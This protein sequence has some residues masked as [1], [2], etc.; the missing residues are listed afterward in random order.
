MISTIRTTQFESLQNLLDI[1]LV[2]KLAFYPGFFLGKHQFL[3]N[4]KVKIE[5]KSNRQDTYL[6][7]NFLRDL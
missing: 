3:E 6:L 4:D 1:S 7:V 5:M 2:F